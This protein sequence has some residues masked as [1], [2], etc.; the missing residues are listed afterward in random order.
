MTAAIDVRGLHKSYG[1]HVALHG[2]N[3]TV[4]TG[5]VVGFIGPN[6]AGKSTT[7]RILLDILRPDRGE[8]RVLG[9]DPRSGGAAL[10]SRMGYLPG[11]LRLNGRYDVATLLDHYLKLSGNDRTT[12]CRTAWLPLAERLDLD[13]TKTV[14]GL[15]KG[16]KQKVG[17]IQAFAHRPE[18]LILDEP[19]SG[20]DPLVQAEFLG[21]VREARDAGQT[22]FLSSHVL[23]EIDQAANHVIVLRRGE[24]VLESTVAVLR[25]SVAPRITLRLAGSISPEVFACLPG[26]KSV[27]VIP[28]ATAGEPTE[29]TTLAI[30][31]DG[32]PDQVVKT[33][34]R[35]TV[36]DLDAARPDLEEAVMRL[37]TDP[38]CC[39]RQ[40]DHDDPSTG[41]GRTIR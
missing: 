41:T 20:L 12:P 23:S 22:V 5:D 32:P 4:P 31:T 10:R 27:E 40:F 30:T 9:H 6:G 37:Y 38:A 19:T 2:I 21:M 14:R 29:T 26:V 16:N 34:A 1:V 13:P 33:A 24:V 36:L 11:E 25:A 28:S 15:S 39:P 3:L 17:L 35:F 18:L 7:M 8:V